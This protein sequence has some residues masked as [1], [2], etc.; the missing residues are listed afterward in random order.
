MNLKAAHIEFAQLVDLAENRLTAEGR[1]SLLAH[2]S[3]CQVCAGEL[4]RVN[5][6][7][8]LMRSDT[9]EDVPR[10]VLANAV[11]L[12]RS[13]VATPKSTLEQRVLAALT[14]DSTQSAPAYGLRSGASAAARQMLYTAGEH[15]LDLRIRQQNATSW[16]IAGQLM[17]ECG[18][19]GRVELRDAND[20]IV[21]SALLNETCEF[22]LPAIPA[23]NYSLRLRFSGTEIEVTEVELKA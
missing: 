15:D 11:N 21:A 22:A 10:H 7:V 3:H 20:E 18:D 8:G 14:F 4:A 5:K 12:F 6:V 23:G 16:L 2:T 19:G 17:G 13:R 9:T 1:E